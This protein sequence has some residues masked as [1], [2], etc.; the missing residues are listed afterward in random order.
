MV[1]FEDDNRP[2][3]VTYPDVPL[4]APY[5]GNLGFTPDLIHYKIGDGWSAWGHGYTGSVYFTGGG[6]NSMTFTLPPETRAFYFYSLPNT[7]G[8]YSMEATAQD[9]TTSGPISVTSSL[10]GEAKYFGFYTLGG[11]EIS[12]IEVTAQTGTNGFA[13]G[14][15][16]IFVGPPSEPVAVP[17]S[18]W[19]FYLGI[20]LM[21]SFVVIRFRRIV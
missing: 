7:F 1:P 18:S 10:A 12:Q 9:G 20:F 4:P 15:F 6:V 16:G 2:T 19:A 17:L 5:T 13:V 8:T 11:V 3:F 21:I 14:E